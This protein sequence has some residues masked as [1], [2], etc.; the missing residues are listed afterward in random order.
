MDLLGMIFNDLRSP[1]QKRKDSEQYEMRMYPLG[2]EQ[3]SRS[4][5]LLCGVPGKIRNEVA[6]FLFLVAKQNYLNGIELGQTPKNSAIQALKGVK[7]T[8]MTTDKNIPYIFSLAMLDLCVN[9]MDDY[10]EYEE[11]RNLEHRLFPNGTKNP[12]WDELPV[13][14]E[15]L[16]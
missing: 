3:R 16:L 7:K 9:S 4:S 1:E 5:A 8:F 15:E 2:E 10:P 13:R 12:N 6:V 11:V 14:D